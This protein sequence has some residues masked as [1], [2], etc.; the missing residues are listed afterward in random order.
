MRRRDHFGGRPGGFSLLE[1]LVVIGIIAIL[2]AMLLPTL[3]RAREAALRVDCMN[4]LRQLVTAEMAYVS[5]NKGYLT[6]PNWAVN[7]ESTNYWEIGWLYAQ[8]Q[9]SSPLAQKDVETGALWPFV[10]NWRVY[11]CPA[12]ATDGLGPERTDRLT[13]YLMNGAVCGYGAVGDHNRD[14][15]IWAPSYKITDWHDPSAQILWWEAEEV[16]DGRVAWNDGSSYPFENVLAKRHGHGASVGCF[17]GHV[18]WMD[19]IDFITEYQLPGP[20]R[21][22]CDPH[23]DNGGQPQP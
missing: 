8:G 2:L 18:E 14:P 3:S 22:Y 20:N 16:V 9:T 13:S 7:L 15:E 5:E 11:H 6:Y 12:H 17:D 19:R 21:L 10:E 4:N 23:Q 1:L